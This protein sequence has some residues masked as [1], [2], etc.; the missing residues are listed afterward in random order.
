LDT[1]RD[2][3]PLSFGFNLG[4]T[5]GDYVVAFALTD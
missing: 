1:T 2:Q 3:A 4:S 5:R